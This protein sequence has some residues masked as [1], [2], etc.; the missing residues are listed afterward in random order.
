MGFAKAVSGLISG[1]ACAVMLVRGSAISGNSFVTD[2][3]GRA[4]AGKVGK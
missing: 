4:M 3:R 2:G 1:A